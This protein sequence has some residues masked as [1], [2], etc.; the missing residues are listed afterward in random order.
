MCVASRSQPTPS[1]P[2]AVLAHILYTHS[3]T[4]SWQRM[5]SVPSR[6]PATTLNA[7]GKPRGQH[8]SAKPFWNGAASD[9]AH[10]GSGATGLTAAGSRSSMKSA[11][12]TAAQRGSA[13]LARE[14]GIHHRVH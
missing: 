13:R 3:C 5:R 7:A 4:R 10:A 12:Q 1:A 2:A 6:A 9:A 14:L 8:A 11:F